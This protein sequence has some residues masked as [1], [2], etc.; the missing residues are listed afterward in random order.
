MLS[1]N[2]QNAIA[3]TVDFGTARQV[4]ENN[5]FVAEK[6]ESINQTV[7]GSGFYMSP[8]MRQELPNGTKT[9][10]W[11]F[12]ITIGVVFGLDELCPHNSNV[13][14]FVK[15]CASGQFDMLLHKHGIHLSPIIKNLMTGMLMVDTKRR[16]TMQQIIDHRYFAESEDTYAKGYN[17]WVSTEAERLQA[18]VIKE[19]Q[20]LEKVSDKDKKKFKT[21][22]DDAKEYYLSQP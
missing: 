11:S 16:F 18:L 5:E 21:M 15:Q 6:N 17:T 10:V 19:E 9:D 3:K 20:E 1:D 4:N 12:A 14:K 7:A 22:T 13:Q 8:E 2:S